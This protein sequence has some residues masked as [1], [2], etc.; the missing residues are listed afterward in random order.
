[1]AAAPLTQPTRLAKAWL[2]V[3][4]S[5]KRFLQPLERNQRQGSAQAV[6]AIAEAGKIFD[7]NL[8]LP[9][10]MFNLL[11]LTFFLDKT[12]FGPVGKV[13]DN[14]DEMIRSRLMSVQGN[15]DEVER[16]KK[17]AEEMI[18]KARAEAQ[19]KLEAA[20]KKKQRRIFDKS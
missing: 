20:R 4:A 6:P 10:Q 3:K 1:M 2:P 15:K 13:L 9:I 17:E 11:A 14:R 16:L 18:Q 7:F 12:W 5:Q 8:T 19:E